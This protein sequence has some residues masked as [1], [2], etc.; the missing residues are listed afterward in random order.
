MTGFWKTRRLRAARFFG[1]ADGPAFNKRLS[2]QG[3]LWYTTYCKQPFRCSLIKHNT[4]RKEAI[5]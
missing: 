4:I 3:T 2:R 1:P 5:L